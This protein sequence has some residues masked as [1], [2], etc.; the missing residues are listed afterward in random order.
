MLYIE[1]KGQTSLKLPDSSRDM[2]RFRLQLVVEVK[3][4]IK[5]TNNKSSLS[6]YL[7]IYLSIFCI[8]SAETILG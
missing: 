4:Y 6:I 5:M 1:L 2:K 3:R 8:K 7:S